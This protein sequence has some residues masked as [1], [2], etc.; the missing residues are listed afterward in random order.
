MRAARLGLFVIIYSVNP[1]W[2]IAIR[3]IRMTEVTPQDALQYGLCGVHAVQPAGGSF[4]RRKSEAEHVVAEVPGIVKPRVL[5]A[6][7]K[8]LKAR[9]PRRAGE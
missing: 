2:H 6:A 9:N 4:R 7:Q 5:E 1:P 8:Q 3:L